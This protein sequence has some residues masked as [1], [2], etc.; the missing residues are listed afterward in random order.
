MLE[1]RQ[2]VVLE[3]PEPVIRESFERC[4]RFGCH[5]AHFALAST[6]QLARRLPKEPA[7]LPRCGRTGGCGRTHGPASDRSPAF[8]RATI[9][10]AARA[11]RR[12]ARSLADGPIRYGLRR[13]PL[14]RIV[15][16][17][18]VAVAALVRGE[19]V[20]VDL[21]VAAVV[22]V[23]SVSGTGRPIPAGSGWVKS[24]AM[25]VR[26]VRTGFRTFDGFFS[27]LLRTSRP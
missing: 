5:S 25:P 26:A 15:L 24:C 23:D 16:A 1:Q 20:D 19:E 27:G 2:V 7:V 21:P 10:V 12:E 9:D 6:Y 8:A 22:G 18:A 13:A 17:L 11:P 3:A 4:L 14:P